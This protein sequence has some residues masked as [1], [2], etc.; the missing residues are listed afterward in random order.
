MAKTP[1]K[2]IEFYPDA[3]R[4]FDRAVKTVVKSPPQHRG[5]KKKTKAKKKKN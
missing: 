2:E 4:R 1:E 3:M 5:A